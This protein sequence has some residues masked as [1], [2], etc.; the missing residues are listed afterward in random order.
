M[1]HRNAKAKEIKALAAIVLITVV[2]LSLVAAKQYLT[3]GAVGVVE[4]KVSIGP[5]C[6]VER[7]PPAS[8]GP[9]DVYSSRRL[10]FQP[11]LGSPAYVQLGQDGTFNA[12]IAAGTYKVDLTD[13]AFMGCGRALPETVHVTSGQT[14]HLEISIDT[15]IR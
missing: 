10:I 3:G 5:F 2:A 1:P 13:C 8:C 4:G 7:I 15:G 6:P 11:T 9:S 12:S 14:V